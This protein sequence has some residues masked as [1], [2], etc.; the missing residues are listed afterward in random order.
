MA[1]SFVCE[2]V[3]SL[4]PN[5]VLDLFQNIVQ[6]GTKIE[7]WDRNSGP[8]QRWHFEPL[9][10]GCY[11]ISIAENPNFVIDLAAGSNA[12]GARI[13]LWSRNNGANQQWR[14]YSYG[15]VFAIE[16]NAAPGKVIDLKGASTANGNIILSWP[17]SRSQNQL[18]SLHVLSSGLP[19]SL[20]LVGGLAGGGA[21][22]VAL[23]ICKNRD[24]NPVGPPPPDTIA[25]TICQIVEDPVGGIYR[26]VF[27]SQQSGA[28]QQT[29]T[30]E[31]SGGTEES[32][33]A[34][35]SGAAQ[36]SGAVE[37]SGSTE[38]SGSAE[39]SGSAEATDSTGD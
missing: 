36:E 4:N 7:I 9:Q 18:W 22:A 39:Q 2:L 8:N 23:L 31:Q 33:S 17:F 16:S 6:L 21:E 34:E 3:S 27:G 14:L 26:A 12:E 19:G 5:K 30:A 24:P 37:E 20:G 38:E 11:V 15:G 35:E 28:T 25:D 29:D 32:G 10:N 1:D 13:A